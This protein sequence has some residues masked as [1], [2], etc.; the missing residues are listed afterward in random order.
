[1][2]D[3]QQLAKMADD[4]LHALDRAGAWPKGEREAWIGQHLRAGMN[5]GH[6]ARILGISRERVIQIA[7]LSGYHW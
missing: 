3:H 1:M 2:G 5:P 6:I 4:S 7:R